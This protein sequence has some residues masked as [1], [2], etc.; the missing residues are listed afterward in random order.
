MELVLEGKS[1]HIANAC[2][3]IDRF[4]VKNRFVT[5]LDLI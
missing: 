1:E 5:A 4:G 2:W 3:K